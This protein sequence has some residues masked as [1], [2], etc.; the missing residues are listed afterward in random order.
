[1]ADTPVSL[2]EGDTGEL[3][4]ARR[5]GIRPLVDEKAQAYPLPGIGREFSPFHLLRDR[6][7]GLWIGRGTREL[8]S[9]EE[10]LAVA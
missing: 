1:M 8:C 3:L 10:C 9:W 7:G 4:I 5:D 6:N 2:I